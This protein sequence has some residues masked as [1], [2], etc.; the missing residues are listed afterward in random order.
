LDVKGK[1]QP[2]KL[3]TLSEKVYSEVLPGFEL[4]LDG[5]FGD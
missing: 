5:V 4:D 2:S 1:Y 3:F